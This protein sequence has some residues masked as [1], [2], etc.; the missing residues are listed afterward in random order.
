MSN[1]V[2]EGAWEDVVRRQDLQGHRVRVIVLDERNGA[3]TTTTTTSEPIHDAQDPWVK[4]LREWAANH[5]TVS[6]FVDDSR[7]GIYGGTLDDPR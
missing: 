6:H 2:I 7:E 5:P 3:A 1:R 4:Q